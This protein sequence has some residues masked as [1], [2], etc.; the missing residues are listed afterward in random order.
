M[1]NLIAYLAWRLG[2]KGFLTIASRTSLPAELIIQIYCDL[3]S[4]SDALALSSA[5]QIFRNVSLEHAENIYF[6]L[7]PRCIEGEEYA[8]ALQLSR[9]A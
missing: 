7:A 4:L 9:T 3:D 1:R 5:S 8:R 2:H 6:N